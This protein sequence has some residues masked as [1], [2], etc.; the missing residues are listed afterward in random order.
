MVL[1]ALIWTWNRFRPTEGWLPVFLLG[2]VMVSLIVSVLEAGWVPEDGVVIPT[3]VF[4]L[5][6]GIV[7]AKRPLSPPA[8]WILLS[9]YGLTITFIDLAR[10]WPF[11]YLLVNDTLTLWQFWR[12]NGALFF[13]RIGSWFQAVFSGGSSEETI[14]FAFGLGLV[15]WLLAA[16]AGWSTF[17]LHK[18]LLGLTLMGMALAVNGY[19]GGAPVYLLAIFVGLTALLAAAIH[20]ATLEQEWEQQ[21]VDYS[22]QIRLELALYAAVIAIALLTLAMVLPGI[23]VSELAQRLLSQPGVQQAEETFGRV[24]AGVEQPERGGDTPGGV[25]GSGILPRSYLLG[26]PPELSERLM[27]TAVV[28]V[29]QSNGETIP[30]TDADLRGAHWRALSYDIYTGRGWAQSEERRELIPAGEPVPLP[31]VAG[32]TA[33]VQQV[34]WVYD[35]RLIRYTLGLPLQIDQEITAVWRG[36]TDLSRILA[37]E[38]EADGNSYQVRTQRTTAPATLL[39]E[40]AVLDVPPTIL[41]RYTALPATVPQR[42]HD[43]AQDVAGTQTN[44]YEQARA[45]ERFLRQYPYSLDVALPPADVDPVDFFLFELQA[46]YCDYYASAMV[47]MARSVGL[48]ARMATGFLNQPTDENGRQSV[49]QINAHSWAEIYFAGYGWVEF[50]PTATFPSPQEPADADPATPL[51]QSTPSFPEAAPPPL[52]SVEPAAQVSWWQ[53]GVLA[54]IG[55]A[56]AGMWWWQRRQP[57][58]IDVVWTYG[59]L[60]QQAGKIGA[61]PGRHQ[62]PHEFT[63]VFLTRLETLARYGWIEP[64]IARLRPTVVQMTELFVRRQYSAAKETDGTA[65]QLWQQMKRPLWQLRIFAKL[66][67]WISYPSDKQKM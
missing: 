48:P 13:D 43:L 50:E 25:G 22:D 30:A 27:M 60:Q 67:K 66:A 14:V 57:Q 65:R 6:L 42:V 40:T 29:A 3:A 51:A 16:Y 20:Y 8:S 9:L 31:A 52:P 38:T 7:L 63:A 12:Q 61:P 62:T 17:R 5:L 26:N 4:G 21:H 46:G 37:T 54:L 47:V 18:P 35:R 45:L 23:R 33:Y 64:L 56:L 36:L 41:A 55:I 1:R 58:Q 53:Y 59:R 19:Y 10:L 34:D 49:Y 28:S 32:Q 15:A 39:R 2:G 11:D 44:P 24:F